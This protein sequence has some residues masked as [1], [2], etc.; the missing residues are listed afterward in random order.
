MGTLIGLILSFL[1][2]TLYAIF[3]FIIKIFKDILIA[4]KLFFPVI[5]GLIGFLLFKLGII[6]YGE[7]S[8][9]IFAFIFAMSVL[10]TLFTWVKRF[11][12]KILANGKNGNNKEE[13][14]RY[15][16]AKNQKYVVN[17]PIQQHKI[18]NDVIKPRIYGV[19]QNPDYIMHEYPDRYELY[20]K[21]NNGKEY[22]RTD[23]KNH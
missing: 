9:L 17:A 14:L 12:K 6:A 3:K 16:R 10:L 22:I 21:N 11:N 19:K 8:F 4:T 5:C 7:I 1:L 23:Y 2:N 13:V 20:K 18:E 15:K